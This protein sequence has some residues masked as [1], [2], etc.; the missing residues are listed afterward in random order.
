LKFI[1]ADSEKIIKRFY[2]ACLGWIRYKP[3]LLYIT[4]PEDYDQEIQ[5]MRDK[6]RDVLPKICAYFDQPEFMNILSELEKY[7]RNVMKHHQD[8]M[9]TKA[10]WA[11]VMDH[12]TDE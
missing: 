7:H 5:L 1:K 3:L 2:K 9:E 11:K 4:R 6:L 8:F 12:L 10:I